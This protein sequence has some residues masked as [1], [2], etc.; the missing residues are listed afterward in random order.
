V[1]LYGISG[2]VSFRERGDAAASRRVTVQGT[3]HEIFI[4]YV[5][6]CDGGTVSDDPVA[7]VT[8]KLADRGDGS[9]CS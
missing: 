4:L 1:D 5:R 7:M 8:G 2:V 6:V 9:R 3:R